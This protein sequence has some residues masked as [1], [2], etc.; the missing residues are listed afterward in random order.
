MDEH[1]WMAGNDPRAMVEYLAGLGSRRKWRLF[2]CGC[3]RGWLPD[4]SWASD[5]RVAI[6]VA[7]RHID[8]ELAQGAVAQAVLAAR[9]VYVAAPDRDSPAADF[10]TSLARWGVQALTADPSINV[11]EALTAPGLWGLAGRPDREEVMVHMLREV[12]GNPFRPILIEPVWL[13]WGDATAA[14]LVRRIYDQR[15]FDDL[16]ILADALEDAGCTDAV[17]LD[18]LRGPGPHVRGCFVL[19]LLLNRS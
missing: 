17:I 6:E 4:V 2:L 3:C 5:A 14:R 7:E 19:D 10:F 15:S 13:A 1:D 11:A 16:P 18:H 8:G 12:F 9:E